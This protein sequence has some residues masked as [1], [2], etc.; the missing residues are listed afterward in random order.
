MVDER[1]LTESEDPQLDCPPEAPEKFEDGG[2]GDEPVD[3]M[4]R[5]K[6]LYL[7]AA[8]EID[9]MRRRFLREREELI[10]YAS[11]AL[12]KDLLPVLD[13]LERA[14]AYGAESESPELK[15]LAD[16][17]K[18][19]LDQAWEVLARHGLEPIEITRGCEFNPNHHEAIGYEPTLE[20]PSGTV[21]TEVQRG[22]KLKD[23]LIRP[24]RVMV[25]QA[26]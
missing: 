16:G 1:K 24:A 2:G 26:S 20:V 23:R 10:K 15:G 5:Y 17:V 3:E 25:A 22:Y 6:D 11:E 12:I 8:A 13:N 14:L 21:C 9:N 19:T 18:M 7:R 4:D